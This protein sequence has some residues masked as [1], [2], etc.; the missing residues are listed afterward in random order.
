[1]AI[2][3]MVVDDDPTTLTAVKA[4]LERQEAV[5]S[6]WADSREAAARLADERFDLF[7]IDAHMPGMDG[8]ELTRRIRASGLNS[9]VPIVML[10][11]SDDGQTMREGFKAGITFFLGKPVN[12]ARLRGLL[13]TARGSALKERR[14]HVRIPFR[15]EVLYRFGERRV[16]A[17]S[18]NLGGSGMSFVPAG[19]LEEGQIVEI[20]FQL[21]GD[22]RP[23]FLHAKVVRMEQP[24]GVAVE[25]VDL[26][27][28]QRAA[29][30]GF[31][32]GLI[33]SRS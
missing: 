20:S 24:E 16:K 21:P 33:K 7:M 11:A 15:T 31:F 9:T 32:E 18:L 28:E 26:P 30:R 10:T 12:F 2:R 6:A 23:L 3:V 22:A 8:F 5:V 1:M 13:Q 17:Q 19:G 25:F 4:G 29:L 27:A 14:R